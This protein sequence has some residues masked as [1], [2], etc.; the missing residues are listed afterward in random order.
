MGLSLGYLRDNMVNI[1]DDQSIAGIK[2]FSNVPLIPYP[3]TYNPA[4]DDT[5]VV[6]WGLLK[7]HLP[8]SSPGMVVGTGTLNGTSGVTITHNLGTSSHR[9]LVSISDTLT[10]LQAADIGV[11]WTL[12]GTNTDVVYNTGSTGK[13]FDWFAV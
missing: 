9:L 2:T 11:I 6:S 5:K 1:T 7:A 10:E 12:K 13:A 3:H 4:G 8:G